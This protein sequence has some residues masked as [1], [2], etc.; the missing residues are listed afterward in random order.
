MGR[1][2]EIRPRTDDLQPWQGTPDRNVLQ[3]LRIRAKLGRDLKYKVAIDSKRLQELEK[4]L[5]QDL[6]LQ[7]SSTKPHPFWDE[8]P[9]TKVILEHKTNI[10][11]LTNPIDEIRFGI[12]KAH[13][14][15]AKD[16]EDAQ[17]RPETKFVIYNGDADAERKADTVRKINEAT[18]KSSKMTKEAKLWVINILQ[19]RYLGSSSDDSIDVAIH[20]LVQNSPIEFLRWA[21]ED[22]ELVALRSLILRAKDAGY[23]RSLNGSLMYGDIQLGIDIDEAVTTLKHPNG[24][25]LQTRLREKVENL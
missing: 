19:G 21:N 25:E 17:D 14:Y 7:G 11:D 1:F 6:S 22:K 9:S 8:D 3:P 24:V 12:A 4:E 16:L 18:I 2:V 10:F 13:D 5:G 23:I 15:V 20:D